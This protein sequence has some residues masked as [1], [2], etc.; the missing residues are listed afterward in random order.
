MLEN[1]ERGIPEGEMTPNPPKT[2][3]GAV[4]EAFISEH[5]FCGELDSNIEDDR[6]SMS[7]SCGAEMSRLLEPVA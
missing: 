5:E 3:L 2:S 6:V 1:R 4:L 7:C